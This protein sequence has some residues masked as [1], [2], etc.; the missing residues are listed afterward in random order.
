M[1]QQIK[2][3][4][5]GAVLFECDL[6]DETPS[7][8]AMRHAL[9]KAVAAKTYLRGADLRDAD[10][11][12]ADL[13]G[14]Y[15]SDADLRGADLRGAYLSDADLRGGLER[16]TPEQAIENLDRVRSIILDDK[17]RLE[18]GH[19]HGGT[20]WE[21]R[22]CAEEAVCGTTHCLAGWLQV[23]STNPEMRK[24]DAELAGILCA[25][26]ASKMFFRGSEEVLNWLDTRAYAT[27]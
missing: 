6:P 25:P 14:A 23:C 21:D 18:M 8:L 24:I 12:D 17:T 15:L 2:H 16:A 27:E 19:W 1:K 10:L 9:E 3:W 13:R 26:V 11:R 20:D 7:G 4:N 5:T 22:T